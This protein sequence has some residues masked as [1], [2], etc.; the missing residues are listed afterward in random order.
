MSA[1][2]QLDSSSGDKSWG[3]LTFDVVEPGKVAQAQTPHGIYRIAAQ[4]DD[5]TML[6][7]FHAG[8]A[9]RTCPTKFTAINRAQEEASD[10]CSR[11]TAQQ[12]LNKQRMK[13]PKW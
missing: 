3:G 5:R 9:V 10:H 12:G 2:F 8:A 4:S 6:L 13:P 1:S 7:T 11:L